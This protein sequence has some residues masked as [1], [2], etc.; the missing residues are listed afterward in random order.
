MIVMGL[1]LARGG[2]KGLPRK[3][4][5]PLAGKPLIGYTIEVA[6]AS[7]VL[8]RVVVSTDDQEI[9]GVAKRYGADVPFYRPA[10]LAEDDTS[11]FPAI[12]HA[13]TWLSEHEG[14]DPGY[15]M[16]LQPTSPFRTVEDIEGAVSLAVRKHADAVVSVSRVRQHPYWSKQMSED[17]RLISQYP[18][19]HAAFRRQDLPPLYVP[20][21]AIYLVLRS[22]LL[23]KETVYTERTYGYVIPAERSLD[24]DDAW[25][26]HV[27]ELILKDRLSHEKS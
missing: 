27:A 3:N 21:G 11:V 4:I 20:N 2:S 12:L 13:L 16:L 15:V 22:V 8:D 5:L 26:L 6:R 19:E 14:Y 24:I 18:P 1:I 10:D 17:G 9:A 7:T 25:D 23:E